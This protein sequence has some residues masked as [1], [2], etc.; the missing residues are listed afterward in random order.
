MRA[1]DLVEW[2]NDLLSKVRL[3][4]DH[5]NSLNDETCPR[6]GLSSGYPAIYVHPTRHGS[7][8][9]LCAHGGEGTVRP[10]RAHPQRLPIRLVAAVALS[11]LA[12]TK[13]K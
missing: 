11:K 12:K 10:C 13:M 7:R 8:A 5:L 9:S 6:R 4:V 1:T 3:E 2:S